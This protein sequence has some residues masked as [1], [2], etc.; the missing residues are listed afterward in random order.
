M[1]TSEKLKAYADFEGKKLSHIGEKLLKI[2]DASTLSTKITKNRWS[3]LQKDII[4]GEKD[5]DGDFSKI[6]FNKIIQRPES[7]DITSDSW[8]MP[9]EHWPYPN[10]EADNGI[11][12]HLTKLKSYCEKNPDRKEETLTN[13]LQGIKNYI[14]YGYATWYKWSIANWGTKWG[15]YS[16]NDK[17]DTENTIYFQTAL[18]APLKVIKKLS[19]LFPLVLIELTYA[20]E[21][22]GSNAG[23]VCYKAGVETQWFKPQSQ[24]KAAYEIYFELNPNDIEKYEL[25]DGVYEY[26]DNE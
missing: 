1:T 19:E 18:N 17:R 14:D 7:L 26:K 8:L 5:E 15:A 2:K 24:S 6:D 4:E 11:M 10:P 21:D 3:L 9:I 13:F 23:R 20:D 25:I 22:S 16:Q 12:E